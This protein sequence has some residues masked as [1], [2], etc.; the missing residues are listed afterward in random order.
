MKKKLSIVFLLLTFLLV[1][2]VYCYAMDTNFETEMQESANKTGETMQNAG[3]G[4]RN[5]T[6][7]IGNMA[8]DVGNSMVNAA[9]KVGNGIKE[10]FNGDD[11]NST[12]GNTYNAT[13]TS[14]DVTG[15]EASMAN[16]AWIWLI[17]GVTGIIIIALTWYYVSQDTNYNSRR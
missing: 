13:R 10:F 17:L 12:T 16:T 9:E 3:N 14:A 1:S 5:A 15:G 11:S 6:E 2:S 4:I 7:G 8:E